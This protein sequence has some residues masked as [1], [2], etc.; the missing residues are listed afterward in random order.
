MLRDTDTLN[1]S[2]TEEEADA[3]NYE[4]H[5]KRR[6]RFAEE[7]AAE[8]AFRAEKEKRNALLKKANDEARE[9]RFGR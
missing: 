4:M 2:I 5:R 6:E 3:A 8:E 7:E 1:R 9:K